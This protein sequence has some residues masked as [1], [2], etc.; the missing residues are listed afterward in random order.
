MNYESYPDL[1]WHMV[2][3]DGALVADITGLNIASLAGIPEGFIFTQDASP[4]VRRMD[5]RSGISVPTILWTS[6]DGGVPLILWASEPRIRTAYTPW[7]QLAPP[8]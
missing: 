6:P 4:H 5:T 2:G 1:V 8:G 3:R 7:A